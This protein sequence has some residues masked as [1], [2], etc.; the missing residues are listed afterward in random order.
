MTWLRPAEA[1][2]HLRVSKTQFYRIVREPG[3]PP[4]RRLSARRV[5]YSK[6]ELDAWMNT[7]CPDAFAND[8]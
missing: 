6:E 5:V 4:G 1:A 7:A 2:S 8:S 3:F